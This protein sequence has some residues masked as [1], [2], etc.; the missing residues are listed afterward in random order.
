MEIKIKEIKIKYRFINGFILKLI[1]M[2]TM[3]VDHTGAVFFPNI[4]ILR[5]IGRLSFPIFCFL[6]VEGYFYTK[7][8]YKYTIRLFLFALISEIPYDLAFSGNIID[9]SGQ[10]V[11]FTLLLGLIAI[12]SFDIISDKSKGVVCLIACFIA[13]ELLSTDYAG[14]GVLMII[15]FYLFRTNIIYS[16]IAQL[17][18]NTLVYGGA[19]KYASFAMIPIA[20]YNGK[21]GPKGL[22]YVFYFFYPVHLLLLYIILEQTGM[23]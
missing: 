7:N 17:S 5:I 22:K 23:V 16:G 10:N 21:R 9:F 13:A 15:M 3:V 6:L 11:F 8:I 20:F 18:I 2:I 1:A 4:R 19:Q 12:W 14:G